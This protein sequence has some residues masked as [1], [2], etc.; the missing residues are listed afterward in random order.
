MLVWISMRSFIAIAFLLCICLSAHADWNQF[1]GS[2]GAGIAE[3]SVPTKW[4]GTEH[5]KWKVQLP[6][7]GTSSPIIVG[8]KVFITCWSGYA[9]SSKGD[10][11][12]LI[13]H[14]ACIDK[15]TGNVLW[16]RT[17]P[18]VMPEDPYEGM[19]TEHGYASST[20]TSDGKWVFVFFGKTG[21]LAFDMEGNQ[22]WQTSVGT[23]S[24]DRHWGSASSPVLF[25]D[26]VI[27]NALTEGGAVVALNKATGKEVWKAGEGI[28]L[29]YST[30]LITKQQDIVVSV[31]EQLW[32]LSPDNGQFRWRAVHRL[33][34]DVSANAILGDGTAYVFGGSPNAG[35]A[36]ISQGTA[37]WQSKTSSYV[38]LPVLHE[39]RLYVINDQGFALC[40]DSKAGSE[41]Y[42]ERVLD[43]TG[44]PR[45][46]GG[47]QPFYA[48]PVLSNGRI[49]CP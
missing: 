13:R 36:A 49:F 33:G 35:S 2:N 9:D 47:G 12:Q 27:V 41:I 39:G 32:G 40:I 24:D 11:S 17:V 46:G 42:R 37:V 4:S 15:A 21:V 3:G 31:R 22:L 6:G 10:M 45:R 34:S 29:A 8:N 38:P 23:H 20:P 16:D 14:L 30:P 25:G 28:Q 44:K 48:S 43:R 26:L 18:A 5:L 7:P 19:I 1:R